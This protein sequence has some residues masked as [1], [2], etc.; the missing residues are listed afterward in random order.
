MKWPHPFIAVFVLFA[1]AQAP[2][3]EPVSFSRDVLPILSD[4]CFSCHGP[5][6]G[7]RKADLR[8]DTREGATADA[9]QA[10]VPGRPEASELIRRIVSTDEDEV[11]PPPKSH[12]A[13]LKPGQTELLRRWI[14]EG[15]AWGRHWALEKPVR[16]ATPPG[17]HPID[18]LVA[19]RLRQEALKPAAPAARVTQIRRLSFDL[20]GLPPTPAEM[21]SFLHDAAPDAYA[22]LVARLLASP[23]F[24]ERMAMWWLDA[25]RYADT[26][27]FQADADRNNWPWRDW[28]VGA[29]NGNLPF[30]RFT[31]EQF[32]GDLLP[33]ATPE[34]ILATCFHRNHMTNGEG[35]RDPEES[36]VDYV[37]DRV[38]TV[39][40]TWLGLTLGCT[41]CHSH[42]FDPISH[43][44]YYSLT[45]FFNSIDE[46]GK[47]GTAAKPYLAYQ[48]PLTAR[49]IAD[50][51][52]VVAE[53]TPGEAQAKQEAA[54][55]F[56]A[57]LA[58]RHAEVRGGFSAWHVLTATA[59][60]S[61][62]GTL[63]AQEA[64]GAV[65]ASGP[66]PNQDDYRLIAA[67]NLPRVTG[68]KLE[69]L[70][71]PSHSG[72][73][74]SR[75]KSGE[76]ILTDIKVQ[77]RRRGSS[78]VRDV[79][80]SSAVADVSK[81]QK[82]ARSYGDIKGVLD[83]DPRNGWT[84][85]GSPPTASYFAVFALAEPVVLDADEELMFE[86]R[87]RST[88]GDANIGRFRLSASDQ[89]G[90]AVRSLQPAPLEELARAQAVEPSDIAPELRARLFAQFLEDHAPYRGPRSALDR[91]QR[92][93]AEVKRAAG[94]L[95]VMVLAERAAPRETF[96][97]ERGVWD[98]HGA[99]VTP[100]VPAAIAP[101][102]DGAPR[103]RLGLARWIVSP[104]NPLTARVVVNHFWQMLFG[105]GLVRTP[106][107]FGLQGERPV[108]PE[109]L[110]WLAVEFM[111][112]GW[113][114][115]HLL[116]VIVT[117]ATYRQESATAAAA[118]ERDP[119]NRFLA[120]G[121]RF[122]LPSWML[123]DAALRAAGLLNP[124]LG[125]PP[126]RPYQPEGVWEEMFMG[127]FRYEP[128][129]GPA[130]Y[131]RT[132]YAFWRRA[133]APT[134]LFDSAQRRVCEVGATRT[135]TPLQALTLLNDQTY[136][137]AS[138]ALATQAWHAA[139]EPAARLRLI[140]RRVLSR[141][142]EAR[143]LAVLERE[144]TR[145][146]AHYRAHPTDAA[147]FLRIGQHPPDASVPVPELAAYTLAASLTLN[148][149]EA[150]T[151]E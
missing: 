99:R 101:W 72:G 92:Q 121:A 96:V 26:D 28:V 115:K 50:A 116:T 57:W 3:A 134:F 111:A 95:N 69:V 11:M 33:N 14:A 110:D 102:P 91:A 122:R 71:H 127:R 44:D 59:L 43:A 109:I 65:Q 23:H 32:A 8:L 130:Q 140:F 73:G 56:V 20:T 88:G 74:L 64:D 70:P 132:L 146:L 84:T 86:L 10:V 94:R 100:D 77:V 60:E 39:G 90:E 105:A 117:S 118:L 129:E 34:Q 18:A 46:D 124:T 49:A 67:V 68:L 135:N 138:R 97:L 103:N 149:D 30:D 80:V 17:Q 144:V 47:A 85:Q 93:L 31:I 27:G 29:F 21:E 55:P 79:A 6:E 45:A 108:Y 107:D 40:T 37:I 131:R 126:V 66:N 139:N 78:Q 137:E 133:V 81:A 53:R 51:E 112:S 83:D 143:E 4:N 106:E 61:T 141:E 98:K 128:S 150:L 15:A 36:R 145:A 82:D 48:S 54:A 125:G 25:A 52:K 16:P 87:H 5:D 151:H 35:G 104:E 63:L 136:L 119:L 12:K 76:F 58:A 75:G 62:E 148:L 113:D 22:R 24:G 19:A 123:R 38:N 42:K 13:R 1:A 41:Q 7:H 120:R 142:P 147:A 114:V 9:I 2:A 89:P